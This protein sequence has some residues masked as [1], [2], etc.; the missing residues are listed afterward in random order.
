MLVLK[1]GVICQFIMHKVKKNV[2][3]LILFQKVNIIVFPEDGLFGM[4]FSRKGLESY[5]EYIPDPEENWN[6]CKSPEKYNNT[7]IQQDLSCMAIKSSLFVVANMGDYQPCDSKKDKNCPKDGHY[8]FYT[9]VVY[10]SSG[11]IVAKYHTINLFFEKQFDYPPVPKAVTFDTDFG[12]FAVFTCFDI[13][14]KNPAIDSLKPGVGNVV[15]P[16]AWMDALPLLAAVQYHSAFAAGAKVNL[17][18][19]NINLP[20]FR[21]HGSGIYSP[22]G[23]SAFRYNETRGGKLLIADRKS[24]V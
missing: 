23:F 1:V 17:L 8:Q 6:P 12:R 11:Y 5:L 4:A 18:A 10:N 21:F 16:T 3:F 24:V 7:E 14:F 13:L 9:N 15:F 19:A 22:T 2:I 20:L